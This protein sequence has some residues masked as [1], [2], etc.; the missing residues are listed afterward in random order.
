[1]IVL[2]INDLTWILKGIFLL[3]IGPRIRLPIAKIIGPA[4]KN[5]IKFIAILSTF[6]FVTLQNS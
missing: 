4:K 6:H 3:K 1:M 5:N 2:T